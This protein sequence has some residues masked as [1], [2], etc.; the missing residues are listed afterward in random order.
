MA[1]KGTRRAVAALKVAAADKVAA[2]PRS[3]TVARDFAFYSRPGLIHR[4]PAGTV[5][6][7]PTEIAMLLERRAPLEDDP[8][9]VS[10]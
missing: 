7:D 1:R 2:L 8:C 9:P 5:V 6:T 4:W 3:V 10:L